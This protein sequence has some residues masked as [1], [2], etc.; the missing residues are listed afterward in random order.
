MN[1]LQ[2]KSIICAGKEDGES[3]TADLFTKSLTAE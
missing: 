2:Q 1:R 3:N